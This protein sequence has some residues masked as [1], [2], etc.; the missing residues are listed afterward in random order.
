[1]DLSPLWISL[2]T[3]FVATVFAVAIGIVATYY[4]NRLGKVLKGI[5]DGLLTL[6]MVLP[7][8]VVGFCLLIF[9]RLARPRRPVFYKRLS[10]EGGFFLVRA[11]YRL[12]GGGRAAY[13]P[14]DA[15]CV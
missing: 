9:F 8:T 12:D 7:P 6:P 11:D 3:A 2:R 4:V 13:V 14:H 5:A 1:M 15:W 10:H